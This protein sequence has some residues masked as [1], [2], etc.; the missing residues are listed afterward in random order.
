MTTTSS[1][2]WL[3]RTVIGLALLIALAALALFA[4]DQLARHRMQRKVE[5]PVTAVA[6]RD[7][8]AALERGRYLF[9]S[10][11]CV[12]CH[13]AQGNGRLFLDDG[14]GMRIAGPNISPGPGSAVAAYGPA[15]WERTIR[16]GVTPQ[17]RALMVMP[18]EDYNR[19]TDDDLASLVAYLRHLA[20]AEGG[21]AVVDLPLPVRALYGFG[22]IQDA[23]AKIDHTRPPEQP[24]ADDI[25]VAH[26]AY[27]ANM[28]LG[29]HGPRLEGG[30]IPG[31]PPD[32]PP[33]ARL[34]P[35]EGSVM[36]RYAD[37]DTF[38]RLF[39]T[40]LRPDGSAVQVMPFGSLR[41]MNDTDVRALHLY[42]K[43]LAPSK[44]G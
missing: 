22:V 38:A 40:G 27:V 34:S 44:P 21:P 31:G 2:R 26:G 43:S 18:S 13:G 10:R 39:K 16:H 36:A 17:G 20:P 42:L 1:R 6:F 23:A 5:V 4:G 7:D 14:K 37:A 29:C 24:V 30:K 12:D 19:L 32:W 28:C 25:S 33:A 8:A 15:D 41:E 3:R 11:G 9:A 35:G